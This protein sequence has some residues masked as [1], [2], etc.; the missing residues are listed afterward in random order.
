MNV[1][2]FL[3]S[4]LIGLSFLGAITVYASPSNEAIDQCKKLRLLGVEKNDAGALTKALVSCNKAISIDP[5][6]GEGYFWRGMVNA[7]LNKPDKALDDFDRVLKDSPNDV[8]AQS[9]RA[10]MLRRLGRYDEALMEANKILQLDPKNSDAYMVKVLTLAALQDSVEALNTLNAAIA[11][12]PKTPESWM[13]RCSVQFEFQRFQ[14][15]YQDCNKAIQLEPNYAVAYLLRGMSALRLGNSKD[16][17]VDAS[18][19]IQI[20]PHAIFYNNRAVIYMNVRQYE[21]A[22]PDFAKATL[23][24]PSMAEPYFGRG[25]IFAQQGKVKEAISEYEKFF[26]VASPDNPYRLPAEGALKALRKM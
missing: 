20:A 13:L 21:D 22:L 3:S 8:Q 18:R 26:K 15:A 17:I 4:M 12:D 1:K 25:W 5:A 24:D 16:A 10:A 9:N 11:V 23:L 14:E 6:Y 19:A 2:S 7:A